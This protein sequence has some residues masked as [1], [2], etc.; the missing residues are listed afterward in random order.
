TPTASGS[1]GTAAVNN[2]AL[3]GEKKIAENL[4]ATGAVEFSLYSSTFTGYGSRVNGAT[5][6]TA[7]S[8]SQKHTIFSGGIVYMF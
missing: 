5:P 8:L 4:R 1:G 3:T 6:E 2:F 7:S